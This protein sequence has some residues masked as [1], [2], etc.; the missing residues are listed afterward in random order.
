MNKILAGTVVFDN[1]SKRYRLGA[2]GT[3]RGT[4][5]AL[6]RHRHSDDGPRDLW[7]LKDVSFRV[8]PGE[9]L[10]L[11]GSNGAGKTT[12]L[13]LLSSITRPTSGHV[14]VDGRISSLIELGAGFHPELSGR[15]NIFLNGAILGMKREEIR[16]RLDAIIA[17]SELER[18]IDTPVKRYSSGMYVRLGFA[19]A[20][21]VEPDV[22]L[23]DEVLA[24]GDA[25]FRQR[26][27]LRMQALQ[28]SGTTILFVS[29]NMHL[30]RQMCQRAVLLNR[31]GLCAQGTPGDVIAEYERS[32][33]DLAAGPPP[34]R[35][36]S[37]ELGE[38]GGIRLSRID[39]SSPG[40]PAGAPIQSD[41]PA[42]ILID[43]VSM[44]AQPIG[45]VDLRIV[46]EDGI[47]CTVIDGQMAVGSEGS[48]VRQLGKQGQ[49]R[50][51]LDPVQ[52]TT[53]RYHVLV[54]ITDPADAAVIA[55]GQS[56][57]FSVFTRHTLASPGVF[58]PRCRWE[59]D[60]R[61]QSG[62]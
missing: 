40:S 54:Q 17:F 52:L 16:R 23:V 24:V 4:V 59:H 61:A 22:L 15:E 50:V 34:T 35:E 47:L 8:E 53:G 1:V 57:V 3:L 55:S 37:A 36:Q 45:R 33:A 58:V 49:V 13:R 20:A 10:G 14:S 46:R 51:T 32:L 9:S 62:E 60:S 5:A 39:V 48:P 38:G 18:F 31:G 25:S 7:A 56:G 19:V 27:I 43:Y 41:A 29:H 42:T 26:C 11:I 21:F 12:T 28:E 6:G 44:T 30:V 2:L